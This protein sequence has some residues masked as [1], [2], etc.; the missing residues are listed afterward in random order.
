MA[1]IHGLVGA[2]LLVV[3]AFAQATPTATITEYRYLNP[4]NNGEAG[5][6]APT[7]GATCSGIPAHNDPGGFDI[8]GNG[9]NSGP[10]IATFFWDAGA[11]TCNRRL[12]MVGAGGCVVI[13]GNA[14]E[15][16]RV[17]EDTA[18]KS[19][20]GLAAGK[21][22]FD[23]STIVGA[24]GSYE[25]CSGGCL[26]VGSTDYC[27]SNDDGSGVC[28]VNDGVYSG[29]RCT[30][31]DSKPMP[32]NPSGTYSFEP[33]PNPVPEGMCPG[34]VNG[35]TVY[36]PCSR[37]TGK[38]GTTTTST[39]GSATTSVQQESVTTCQGGTCTTVVRAC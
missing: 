5:P 13:N 2:F 30:G 7:R 27:G 22:S 19:V 39:N 12:E 23:V 25:F 10:R 9:G 28:W 14:A 17:V 3:A 29:T 37:T 31:S 16:S 18:C 38:T 21:I 35:A 15:Q 6:W 26:V 20:Q 24:S 36:V 11:Q 34:E 33:R 8:C 4:Y 1:A 32:S